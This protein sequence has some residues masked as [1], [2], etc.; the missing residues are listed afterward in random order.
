MAELQR[1]GLALTGIA[2]EWQR[3]GL[4]LPGIAVEWQRKGLALPLIAVELQRIG[5]GQVGTTE[6][7]FKDIFSAWNEHLQPK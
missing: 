7:T 3:M 5:L 4:A 2:V 1:M 6:S